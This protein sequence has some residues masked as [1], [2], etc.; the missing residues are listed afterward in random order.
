M[1]GSI[2]TWGPQFRISFELQIHSKPPRSTDDDVYNILAF[3]G[4]GG[5][6]NCCNIGDRVPLIEYY[7][8][9]PQG[10]RLHFASAVGSNGNYY[11]DY[12][13][14]IELN[15]TYTFVIEQIT[16]NNEVF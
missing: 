15:K 9:D 4:N 14:T 10:E 7:P 12:Y 3:K 5:T 6:N 16:V 8:H 11:Y 13:D 1:V 2:E